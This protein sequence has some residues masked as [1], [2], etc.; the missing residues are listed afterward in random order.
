VRRFS[1]RYYHNLQGPSILLRIGFTIGGD[2]SQTLAWLLRLLFH[3]H[4]CSQ[5]SVVNGVTL[6]LVVVA[7]MFNV[8]LANAFNAV[9]IVLFDAT[10]TDESL[11]ASIDCLLPPLL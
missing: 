10:V 3:L 8:S 9:T 1:S 4:Q 7:A 5:W 11:T 6:V 2:A